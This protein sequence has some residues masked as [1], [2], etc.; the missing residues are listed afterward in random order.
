MGSSAPGLLGT[1]P[2]MRD[3]SWLKARPQRTGK[4]QRPHP[5]AASQ[6]RLALH[7]VEVVVPPAEE[8]RTLAL[9]LAELRVW[10]THH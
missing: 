3:G 2:T 1:E 7:G 9:I 4:A 8:D 5:L 6:E 10:Q